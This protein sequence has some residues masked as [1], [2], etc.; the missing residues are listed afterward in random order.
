MIA[1]NGDYAIA[2]ELLTEFHL[3]VDSIEQ[4]RARRSDN[5]EQKK[6]F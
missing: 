2:I 1:I 6:Y 4:L 3:I 5:Q